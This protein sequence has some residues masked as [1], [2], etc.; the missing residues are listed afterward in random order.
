MTLLGALRMGRAH[1]E[2]R[3]T[4]TWR[5][6]T[7]VE[8]SPPPTYDPIQT[9]DVV[10]EGPARFKP[11]GTAPQSEVVAGQV[12]TVQAPELHLPAGTTGV[13]VGMLAVCDVC[14]EDSS[15]VGLVVR[16]DS[17]PTRGQVTAARFKVVLSGEVLTE[18]S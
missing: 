7:L 3:M 9:L 5:I 2:G 13:E 17:R 8:E 16:V 18:G 15:L 4:Q 11:E 12:V 6:G 1:A 14:P 10:Y